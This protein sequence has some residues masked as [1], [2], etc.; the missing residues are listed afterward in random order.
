MVF[1]ALASCLA[2][3]SP[4]ALFGVISVLIVSYSLFGYFPFQGIVRTLLSF[5]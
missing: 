4:K 1:V 2:A 5:V 3:V